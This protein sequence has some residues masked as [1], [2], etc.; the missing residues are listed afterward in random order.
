MPEITLSGRR[1]PD[2][3]PYIAVVDPADLERVSV[4]KWRVDLANGKVYATARVSKFRTVLMHR[5]L[6]NAPY[7]SRV[8]HLDG[9]TLNNRRANLEKQ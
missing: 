4:Y 3:T 8:F 2:G 5:L 1:R 7:G 9:D 6:L